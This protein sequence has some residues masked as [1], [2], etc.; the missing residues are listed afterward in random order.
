MTYAPDL[1]EF[2]FPAAVVGGREGAPGPAAAPADRSGPSLFT[3]LQE[4]L[5][6]RL[7]GGRAPVDVL[8]VDDVR[9]P[10][11]N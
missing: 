10:T 11:E 1:Q 3:A 8:V 5:G 6:L 4:Q 9:P 2:P 7:E